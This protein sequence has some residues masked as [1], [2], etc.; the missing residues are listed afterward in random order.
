MLAGNHST[1]SRRGFTLIELLVVIAII[2]ILAALLLPALQRAK[3]QAQGV[4][5]MNN[6]KQL[7]L[8]WKMYADDN[9]GRFAPNA[10][11][12]DQS[13]GTW[14]DGEMKWTVNYPD[15]TN[16]LLIQQSLCG[17]YILN[18]VAVFKCPAD[19]YNCSENG[20]SVPRVRSVS[21]NGYVGQIEVDPTTGGCNTKDW[22]GDG[23]GY[24]AYD[25][26]SQLGNPGPSLL[27]VFVDEHADSIN[28]SFIMFDMNGP[29]FADGPAAYHDG[30]C[31]FGFADGHSE[32]HKWLQ[33]QYWPKV[34]KT[35]WEGIYEPATGPDTQWMFQH[36]AA[37]L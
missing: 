3:Q 24:Q 2:A 37:H 33:G 19:I 35:A 17:P 16:T 36:T 22:G 29:T 9:K 7:T 5:C 1:G 13:E 4:Q 27:W 20:A 10:D 23:A 34:M 18:Q 26:E 32:I 14:C 28:D 31:G 30:A 21:M 12:S 25:R 15:N 11:E 8:A 6:Q